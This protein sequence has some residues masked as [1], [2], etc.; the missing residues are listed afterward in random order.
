VLA[1]V[2]LVVGS[3]FTLRLRREQE[4][5]REA[6]ESAQRYRAQLA[7]E[8]GQA[9]CERGDAASGL[10]WFGH[11]LQ[12]APA[13]D[14]DVAAEIRANLASWRRQVHPLR[15]VLPHAD[16]VRGAAFSPDGELFL[17][18]C[19]DNTARLWKTDTA[20][21][22]GQPWPH[23]DRVN[24]VAFSPDG[25]T[26]AT[27]CH[28]GTVWLWDV[29]TGRLLDRP[30]MRQRATVWSVAFSPD[31]RKLLT[32]GRDKTARLWDVATGEQIGPDL[33]HGGEVWVAAFCPPTA[34]WS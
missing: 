13:G 24:A 32:G 2:A 18:G 31:G 11:S 22:V 34:S 6:L 4:R 9:L 8:R 25:R 12:I 26:A 1:L 15:A 19:W 23:P 27:V 16:M 5:T 14:T 20:E 29:T 10:L 21:L 33:A 3:V 17:T 30:P 28:G 7:L